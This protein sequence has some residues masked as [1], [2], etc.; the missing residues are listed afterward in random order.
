VFVLP[1]PRFARIAIASP[2]TSTGSAGGARLI[3]GSHDP[4]IGLGESACA[5]SG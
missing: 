5:P 1:A 4:Q 2:A 3:E